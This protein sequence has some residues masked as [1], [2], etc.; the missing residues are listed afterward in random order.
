MATEFFSPNGGADEVVSQ[1]PSNWFESE[2]NRV[3]LLKSSF[4]N[5]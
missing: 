4:L 3:S 5:F 2:L 1:F